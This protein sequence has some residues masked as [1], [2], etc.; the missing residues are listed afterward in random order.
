M[1]KAEPESAET[2]AT[3][4]NVVKVLESTKAFLDLAIQALSPSRPKSRKRR[5]RIPGEPAR[6]KARKARP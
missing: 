5:T 1:E 4:G 3:I 2:R 6:A